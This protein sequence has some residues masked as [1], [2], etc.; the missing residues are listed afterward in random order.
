MASIQSRVARNVVAVAET[1]SCA[2]AARVMAEHGIGSVGVRRGRKLLGIVT[3]RDLLG[4][5]VA[6]A[7][8]HRT[9]VS[10]ALRP[11]APAVSVDASAF[12]C[13]LLMRRHR[14]RH[15]AVRDGGEV[16]GVISL[17]DVSGPV[18]EEQESSAGYQ[19]GRGGRAE[20][21]PRPTSAVFGRAALR[22]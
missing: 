5:L 2:E 15:L 8:P 3:E 1:A 22:T 7:D 17:R 20:R 18:L 21:A 9:P 4:Y 19:H 13:A 10:A 12:E 14:T 6:F 16:V 11:D